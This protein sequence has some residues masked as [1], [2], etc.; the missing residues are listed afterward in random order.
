MGFRCPICKK[1]FGKEK[2]KW[3]EHCKVCCDGAAEDV[4]KFVKQVAEGQRTDT[5]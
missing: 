5:L 2:V 3:E 1:D 4:V